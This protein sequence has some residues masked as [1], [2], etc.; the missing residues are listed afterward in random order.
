MKR[1]RLLVV[2][3]EEYIRLA[4]RKWFEGC[5]FEVDVADDGDVAVDLCRSK[6]YDAITMDLVMPRM[7]G[8]VAIEAI[9][10]LDPK[11][12]IVVLTGYQERLSDLGSLGVSKILAKPLALHDLEQEIRA[13]LPSMA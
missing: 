12:P 2:D 1:P 7:N 13:L 11:V 10:N 9:R 3:D 4:L 8:S 5:G 6:S